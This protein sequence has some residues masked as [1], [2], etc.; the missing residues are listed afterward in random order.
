[1]SQNESTYNVGASNK[2]LCTY[3]YVDSTISS[4]FQAKHNAKTR[5]NKKQKQNKKHCL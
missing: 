5:K 3:F 1:M 2:C 4:I